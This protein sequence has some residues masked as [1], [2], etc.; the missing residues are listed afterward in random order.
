M[1]KKNLPLLKDHPIFRK[2]VDELK[3]QTPDRIQAF[4]ETT[5]NDGTMPTTTDSEKGQAGP[6]SQIDSDD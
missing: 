5:E 4:R 1:A 3:Q 6:E 2:M